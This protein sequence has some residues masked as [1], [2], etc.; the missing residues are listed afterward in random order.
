MRAATPLVAT[1]A[2]TLTANHFNSAILYFDYEA[3]YAKGGCG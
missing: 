3:P 1:P 2:K